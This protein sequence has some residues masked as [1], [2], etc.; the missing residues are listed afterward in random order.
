MRS[1]KE[2]RKT[3]QKIPNLQ[4]FSQSQRVDDAN[5]LKRMNK[6]YYLRGFH[7][8]R[9]ILDYKIITGQRH[10]DISREY[11]GRET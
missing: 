7:M 8:A 5:I 3:S 11:E 1:S 4:S 9:E 2:R 10:E 6:T